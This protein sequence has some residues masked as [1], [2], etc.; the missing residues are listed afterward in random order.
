MTYLNHA[1]VIFFS[2]NSRTDEKWENLNFEKRLLWPTPN[3]YTSFGQVKTQIE[4]KKYFF[5]T[6]KN[7]Q[8]KKCWLAS[9][10][11][12]PGIFPPKIYFDD[13]VLIEIG[14]PE[15]WRIK[16]QNLHRSPLL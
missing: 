13:F 2:N 4:F 11:N 10:S 9:G 16:I 5:Y 3:F 14:N 15:D 1:S 8:L 12:L 7:S 6:E